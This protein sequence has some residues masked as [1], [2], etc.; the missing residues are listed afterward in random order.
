[1]VGW[2]GIWGGGGVGVRWGGGGGGAGTVNV[3][4]YLVFIECVTIH[5]FT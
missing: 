4:K 2:S 1:M 3:F 5:V